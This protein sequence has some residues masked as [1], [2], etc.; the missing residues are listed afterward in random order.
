MNQ[1]ADLIEKAKNMAIDYHQGQYRRGDTE[2]YFNHCNRVA[3]HYLISLLELI[4]PYIK[5]A[6]YL[7]DIVEDTHITF[8]KLKEEEFPDEVIEVVRLLTKDEEEKYEDRIN[9]IIHSNNICAIAIKLAD[10]TDNCFD[11]FNEID[12]VDQFYYPKYSKNILRLNLKLN[13]LL[14]TIS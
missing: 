13:Q 14:S 5:A 6:A 9:K 8:E 12:R 4:F 3:N 7:H 1:Y 10:S 11:R 2:P